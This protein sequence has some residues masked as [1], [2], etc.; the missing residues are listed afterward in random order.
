[1]AELGRYNRLRVVKRTDIGIFLDGAQFGEILLPRRYLDDS[2]QPGDEVEV[3][4]YNDSEDRVVATTLQPKAAI[5]TLKR[6]PTN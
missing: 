3:F 2:M 4:L 5:S 1:M 6:W